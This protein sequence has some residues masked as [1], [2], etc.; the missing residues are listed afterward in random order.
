VRRNPQ[1]ISLLTVNS[2]TST[3]GRAS[4]ATFKRPWENFSAQLW[5]ALRD[6]YFPPYTGNISLWIFLHC[7]LLPEKT[8]NRSLLFGNT[9]LKHGR[10]FDYWNHTLNT[11]I[12]MRTR[13]LPWSNSVVAANIWLLAGDSLSLPSPRSANKARFFINAFP[14]WSKMCT[15]KEIIFHFGSH[16]S[17]SHK[18]TVLIFLIKMITGQKKSGYNILSQMNPV[19]ISLFSLFKIHSNNVPLFSSMFSRRF[20]PT[21]LPAKILYAFLSFSMNVHAAPISSS[22]KNSLIILGR[23]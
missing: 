17:R 16:C 12:R 11:H 20:Y 9:L 3:P 5:T 23:M 7:V 18:N 19:H 2:S 6:K 1:Q 21:G 4:S 22:Y 15:F 8:Y 10:H 13:K 14:L